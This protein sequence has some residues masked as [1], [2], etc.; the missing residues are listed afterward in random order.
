M[1]KHRFLDGWLRFIKFS[2]VR[3]QPVNYN[4]SYPASNGLFC[5]NAKNVVQNLI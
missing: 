1:T 5:Y 2:L 4:N 3:I